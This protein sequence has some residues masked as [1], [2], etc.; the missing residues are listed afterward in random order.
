MLGRRTPTP[1]ARRPKDVGNVPETAKGNTAVMEASTTG[2]L[3]LRPPMA[4]YRVGVVAHRGRLEQAEALLRVGAEPVLGPVVNGVAVTMAEALEAVTETVVDDA[5]AAVVFTSGPGAEGWLSAAEELGREQALRRTLAAGRVLVQG[6][7]TG[8]ATAALDVTVDEV[9]ASPTEET[10]QALLAASLGDVAG[11]RVAV[12]F[13]STGCPPPLVER[14]RRAGAVVI[15]VVVP[16]AGLPTD[17]EPALRLLE[18]LTRGR[19]EA[20]TLTAPIEVRNLVALAR[21]TGLG[22]EV[23]EA[24]NGEVTA[25][26]ISRACECV[27]VEFGL[28]DVV[29]PERARVGAM[30]DALADHL[31]ERFVRLH[32]AGVEVV[33]QGTLAVID[34][35]DVWLTH[36]ERALLAALARRPG[37][38]VTKAELLRRVWRSD[39][40]DGA[41]GHAV[42]VAVGRLRRR[43][44][45]A[46]VALQTVPRRGYRLVPA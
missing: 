42:E 30:V 19:L 20:L 34:E 33:L 1:P 12:Q 25:V 15:E 24:L 18:D 36:R 28:I 16:A 31:R 22:D 23:M 21:R 45:P 44:G 9:L 5:P 14:L 13:D 43:L 41:D 10:N 8:E 38:V 3:E 32:L 2:D 39:G 7:A 11:R 27:A 37:M 35:E 17:P 4:G 6:T 29:R 40:I 26:C 46:G